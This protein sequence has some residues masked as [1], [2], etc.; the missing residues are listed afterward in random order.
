MNKLNRNS[1]IVL[2]AA[3]LVAASPLS[4]Q[5]DDAGTPVLEEVV[6]Q[7]RLLSG[8]EAL[9]SER[10]D[11]DVVS[12]VIGAEFI[13]RVGDSTVASALRRVPGLSLVGNKFVYVRGLGER[14]SSSSLNG[15]VVPSPDLTRNVLPLD[16]FPTSIVESLAVR[17]GYSADQPA[18]FG[19][20]AVDI[21]TKGVPN[22]FTYGI[23]L[24]GGFNSEVDGPMLS[25]SG[26][27]DDSYGTDDGTRAYPVGLSAAMDRFRGQFGTQSIL[28][29]LRQEGSN[30]VTTAEATALN[31]ELALNLNRDISIRMEDDSPDYSLR[32]NV[33]N[34]I[35]LSDSLDFGLSIAGS[36]GSK[37]RQTQLIS[38]TFRDPQAEFEDETE[39]TRSVDL[40]ASINMGLVL[41]GDHE[42]STT[43]L[44][45]RNTDDE[46]AQV[47]KFNENRRLP[48]G[49]GYRDDVIKF[50]ER[51]MIVNQIK[52]T[53]YLGSETREIFPWIDLAIFPENLQYDWYYSEARAFTDIPNQTKVQSVTTNDP[54][55]GEELS[56]NVSFTGADFRFTDL[57]DEVINWG[58]AVTLPLEFSNAVAELQGGYAHTQKV[59]T[60]MQTQFGLTI[61][62]TRDQSVLQ[63]PLSSVFS[64]ANISDSSNNYVFSLVGSNGQSYLAVTKTDAVFGNIDWTLDDTWRVSGGV[65]WEQYRQVSLPWFPHSYSVNAPQISNDVEDL[66]GAVYTTEEYYPALAFTYMT[67]FWA[68]IFQLR[69]GWSETVVR[70]DLREIT[71]ASYIDARSG[72]ETDGDSSVVPSAVENYDIRAEWFFSSGDN[73]TVGLYQKNLDDPI[74]FFEAAASDTNRRRQIVN[75]DSG[76][77]TGLEI[78]GLKS[79]GFLGD[80]G[81]QFFVQ[82]NLTLQDSELVAGTKADAPTNAIRTLAGASE[83]VAN[84]LIGFDSDD[85]QHSS[86]LTYNVFGER[87]FSAGRN[88]SP[89]AFEQPFHSL[90]LTYSWYPIDAMTLKLKFQNILDEGIEIKMGEV[91]AFTEK[92]GTSFSLTFQWSM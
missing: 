55:T 79:L 57:D 81:E 44:Y 32:A 30:N 50:E 39:S 25:Y 67:D 83:Y 10:I 68:E 49:L 54:V 33:G 77:V 86:T 47:K 61:Q 74:E 53:H 17:K 27:S 64:D 89:D 59:R 3:S 4:A 65:R 73:L 62:G 84:I 71:D 6:V 46:T 31:R 91:L 21:R 23:E 29:T 40:N 18:S 80:F 90:D 34:K 22:A 78:E 92:P 28:Q 36:Y 19:G 11:D 69:F 70:P 35:T 43:S 38:R 9:V 58:G 2:A 14:Y 1:A 63:G 82:G 12:D 48:D 75:A 13:S 8:A 87:L 88:G 76:E 15:A 26:G 45:I 24:G 52:G 60:Y 37:W 5:E 72:F 16:I 41:A 66:E 42:V 56:S 51:E 7:A 85:G 20:G